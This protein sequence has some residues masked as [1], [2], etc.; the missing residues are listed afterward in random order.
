MNDK[1]FDQLFAIIVLLSIVTVVLGIALFAIGMSS[2]GYLFTI[3]SAGC[4]IGCLRLAR[5]KET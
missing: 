1:T 3:I 5:E 4:S 2:G